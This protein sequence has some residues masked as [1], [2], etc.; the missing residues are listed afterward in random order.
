MA[1]D[2]RTILIVDDEAAQRELLAEFVGSLGFASTT[3]ASAET[4]LET[5]RRELPAMVLL[6]V[7]LPGMSGIEALDE[8]RNIAGDL[9]VLLITAF[10]DLRQAVEAMKHGA[11][12][13]LSKPIDLDELAAAI[14][15]AIGRP[16]VGPV[17]AR[18]VV[19]DLPE[20]IVCVSPP[21]RHLIETAAVVAPSTAAVLITGENGTG[22]EVVA[23]LMHR[24]SGRAKGPFVVANCAGWSES[25]IESE[26][27]GHVK[28]AFTGASTARP[29]LFRAA[30]GGTL[31]LDE[32]GELPLHLQP[33]LLR[34]IESRQIT[35]VGSEAV[36]EV[37]TRLVAATNRDLEAAIGEGK[38]RE[39]HPQGVNLSPFTS[40][41]SWR[42]RHP[43][44]NDGCAEQKP[45]KLPDTIDG[46]WLAR[47]WKRLATLILLAMSLAALGLWQTSEYRQ[48]A[49]SR[50]NAASSEPCGHE[51][52]G[53]RDSGPPAAGQLLCRAAP[54]F[55]GRTRLGG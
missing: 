49:S 46:S 53:R 13:Y 27:F 10:A 29:G 7:R 17:A 25:L 4:A 23:E 40:K 52:P 11:D 55:P 6:D 20:K 8:I 35:P 1:E 33:K 26:L 24:W 42:G 48:G 19:A 3:A 50:R 37:D 14:T 45:M 9:P 16:D 43:R 28:G 39:A 41:G 47:R 34:A 31:F 18:P 15:D 2:R 22:K 21:M 36:I 30:A 5:I 32:I 38:F 12:D 54:G 51:C 44:P